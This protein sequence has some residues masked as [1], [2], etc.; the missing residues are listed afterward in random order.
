MAIL[1]PSYAEIGKNKALIN[2][3]VKSKHPSLGGQGRGWVLAPYPE[4]SGLRFNATGWHGRVLRR[5]PSR[6]HT[7]TIKPVVLI[8]AEQDEMNHRS[9][10][11][12]KNSLNHHG[13]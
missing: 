12:Q 11:K 6:L 4:Q 1:K 9:K 2:L 5:C 10:T 3:F 7:R 8:G 13:S